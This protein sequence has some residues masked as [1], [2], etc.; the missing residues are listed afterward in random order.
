M[1]I[2]GGVT[3][4]L[5]ATVAFGGVA[6]ARPKTTVEQTIIDRNKDNRLDTGP[7]DAYLL[8]NSEL[9]AKTALAKPQPLA[10][11]GQLTDTHVIDEESPL[12]VEFTD[13]YGLIF[14]SAYRP[15][16]GLSAQV[17]EQMVD[18]IRNTTSPVTSRKLEFVMTTG[19][20][21]DNTQCNETRWMIDLLDG[22]KKVDPDSGIKDGRVVSDAEACRTAESPAPVPPLSTCD[23]E[24]GRLYDGV[25][26]GGEYYEPDRSGPPGADSEDGPGYAPTQAENEAEAQRS[27]SVRDFPGLFERQN[28]PF[29][30]T[31]L[32]I[33]WYGIFGNHDGL[34]QGNQPRNPAFEA[35]AISCTKVNSIPTGDI[36]AILTASD[37]QMAVQRAIASTLE[38][39]ETGAAGF[40]SV[41]PPDVRRRPLRKSEYIAQ[42]FNTTGLPKGHGFTA[43]NIA[44][45][46]G[47]YSFAPKP[48]L[49]FIV[50]D[51]V[52][53]GGLEEGNIDDVQFRWLHDELLK[54][55]QAKE[56]TFVFAHH[57]IRTMGQPPISPFL[58][59][60]AD[61]L[62]D[63][64]VHFGDGLRNTPT[65]LPCLTQDRL[66][67]TY[68]AES[69][70]CLLLRH[71]SVI[72]FVNGHEHANRVTP[73]ARPGGAASGG[74]WEINTA[75]HIDWPQQ[76]RVLD[77]IDNRDG[78]LSIV[79][80]VIDH[81]AALDPGDGDASDSV[82]RLASISRELAFNDRHSSNGEDGTSDARGGEGDRNVELVVRDPRKGLLP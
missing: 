18:Q 70:K 30:A 77:V 19:D 65:S 50:L 13:R 38:T 33:P 63:P 8:R 29:E 74:F 10:F 31:G 69:L 80:T 59:G 26:G 42:H 78:S 73:F 44:T 20:N 2:W 53:D 32:G 51:S 27:S 66:A 25:R 40:T 60:D 76:S 11:F 21:T 43:E 82:Q 68:A 9:G 61:P 57:S 72:A 35:L 75:S 58:P 79:A 36:E 17:V 45:G 81:A 48:G 46:E 62:P 16:E 67:P 14:T 28:E 7:G 3:V 24:P 37:K 6:E 54:A 12:R 49:R 64:V 22:D 71:P 5:A 15:Q 1:R 41:V 4:A 55:D 34:I 47:Y 52:A 23:T 56:L 39:A